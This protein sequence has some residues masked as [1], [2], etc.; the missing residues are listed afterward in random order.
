VCGRPWAAHPI[1]RCRRDAGLEQDLAVTGDDH[2][3]AA[4]AAGKSLPLASGEQRVGVQAAF[5]Q[6]D[7]DLLV[8]KMLIL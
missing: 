6:A 7:D 1:R 4:C 8:Q 2:V 3:P 5:S